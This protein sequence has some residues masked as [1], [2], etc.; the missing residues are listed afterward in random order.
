MKNVALIFAG[1]SG[2]RMQNSNR[3]KQF[4]ELGGKPIIIHTI[5]HFEEHPEIDGVVVV[6]IDGWIDFLKEKIEKFNIHKVVDI[7]PGGG[8]G[9][10]SIRNGLYAIRDYVKDDTEN[11]IVLIHDGVRPLIDEKLITDNI[12]SVRKYGNAITVV[13]AIETIIETD[14]DGEITKVADRSRCRMARAPQSFVLSD[15]LEAHRRLLEEGEEEMIDSAMLMQHYGAKLHTVE[16]PSE[17]IKI[18]TP[19]DYYLFRAFVEAKENKQ[20]GGEL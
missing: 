7:V 4:L 11:T 20:F 8:T 12:E 5:E 14:S 1:G 18:T 17:N 19:T 10:E 16:G 9:Q 15:I 13:P 3:P 2:K 6:C